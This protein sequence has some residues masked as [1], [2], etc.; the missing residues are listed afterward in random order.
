[1]TSSLGVLAIALATA[2]TATA[3]HA[4]SSR[5]ED[6]RTPVT[7]TFTTTGHAKPRGA[8]TADSTK[9]TGTSAAADT[10]GNT[11]LTFTVVAPAH[12]SLTITKWHR[13]AFTQGGDGVYSITAAN[14]TA[15][16]PT[17][18]TKVTVHDLL[19]AG[20]RAER[21]NGRG[22]HCIR[23][24]L[25]CTRNDVLPAGHS[26]P[27]ITLKVDVACNARPRVTNI[28]T[29]TGGGDPTRHTATDPTKI[30]PHPHHS[31]LDPCVPHHN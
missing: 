17:D 26:Y 13:G 29:I 28:A 11:G 31:H 18:G 9:K 21:I 3:Q 22:W 30:N 5:A 7:D 24:T 1:M 16:G 12:P 2:W 8:D 15:A 20:L 23:A 27:A 19:P 10:T 4:D 6:R 14:S 25:T